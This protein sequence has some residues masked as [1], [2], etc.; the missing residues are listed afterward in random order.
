[1]K[2]SIQCFGQLRSITK[3]RYVQIEIDENTS[4]LKALSLFKDKYG[5]PIENLLYREGKIRDFYF[6]QID[7]RNVDNHEL[8]N[9]ILREDQVISI[10]PFISGG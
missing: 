6:I 7:K 1:M 10:I 2:V 5:E 8:D 3:D 9:V 4:V